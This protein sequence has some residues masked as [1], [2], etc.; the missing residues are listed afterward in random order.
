MKNGR[1]RRPL[2]RFT[3]VSRSRLTSDG[4]WIVKRMTSAFLKTLSL[5][6]PRNCVQKKGANLL[7]D[8]SFPWLMRSLRAHP[9]RA[10]DADDGAVQ[11][12]VVGDREH[13]APV[14]GGIAEPR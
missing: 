7:S 1:M 4:A 13:Q 14:L 8:S 10:V 5:N 2:A 3:S 9:E 11:V 6:A 12:L